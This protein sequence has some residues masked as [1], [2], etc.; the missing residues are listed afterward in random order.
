MHFCLKR[1]NV[2]SLWSTYEGFVET[3][4]KTASEYKLDILGINMENKS[5]F[6]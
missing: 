2:L 6:L 5:G 1:M 3:G 4:K